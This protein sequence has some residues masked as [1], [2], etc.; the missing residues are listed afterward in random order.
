MKPC[1]ECDVE[2]GPFPVCCACAIRIRAEARRQ[3]LEE[4]AKELEEHARIIPTAG[5]AESYDIADAFK[6]A[7]MTVRNL[8]A[9]EPKQDA[10]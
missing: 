3:A 4:A 1:T 5:D 9:Q 8:A 6:D 10:P 2:S 7:A